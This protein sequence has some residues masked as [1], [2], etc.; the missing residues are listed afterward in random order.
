MQRRLLRE[1]EVQ[2]AVEAV[3]V[4]PRVVDAHE[5]IE[6]GRAVPARLDRQLAPGSAEAVDR[7]DRGD[8][9]P[10]HL[11]RDRIQSALAER[12]QPQPLP[13]VPPQPPIAELPGSRPAHP[14]QTDLDDPFILGALGAVRREEGQLDVLSLRIND[15]DGL[16]PPRGR[17]GVELPQVAHRPL[18]RA[19]GGADGL[20]QRP[21]GVV[22][23][24]LRA[25]VRSQEHRVRPLCATLPRGRTRLQGG[26]STLHRDFMTARLPSSTLTERVWSKIVERWVF[27]RNLG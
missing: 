15:L 17:R 2:T 18:P 4:D 26:R 23:A 6:G 24:V 1:Q 9:R 16:P 27:V 19:I 8:P 12:V 25:P 20:H 5:V 21:V 14:I 11:R 10:R 7:E 3:R 22:L 13:Q